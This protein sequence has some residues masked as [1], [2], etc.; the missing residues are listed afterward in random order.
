MAWQAPLDA[1]LLRQI[2]LPPVDDGAWV[3]AQIQ[4]LALLAEAAR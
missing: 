3:E 4:P 2:W 1:W